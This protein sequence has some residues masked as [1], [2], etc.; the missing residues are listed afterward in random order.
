MRKVTLI[1]AMAACAASMRAQDSKPVRWRGP[2]VQSV[3]PAQPVPETLQKIFGNLG[4]ADKA[5]STGG[6]EILGPHSSA[7]FSQFISLPFTPTANAHVD[8]VRAAIQFLSAGT[9]NE[10]NIGLYGDNA[11][12]P[13]TLLAGP[14][15]VV[16]PVQLRLLPTGH[17]DFS[18]GSRGRRGDSVLD[19]CRYA[20]QRNRER[21]RGSLGR[22]SAHH[23]IRGGGQQWRRLVFIRGKSRTTRRRRFTARSHRSAPFCSFWV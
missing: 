10:V 20:R 8:Q 6:F 3:T 15:T 1:L 17:R 14:V 16:E 13:G 4:P 23:E 19:R 18:I 9:P 12:V 11:G 22:R 2:E 5:Y 7:G 21:L